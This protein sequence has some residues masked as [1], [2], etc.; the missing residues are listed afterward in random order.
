MSIEKKGNKVYDPHH[1][2]KAGQQEADSHTAQ[3]P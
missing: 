3:T 1:C 2:M